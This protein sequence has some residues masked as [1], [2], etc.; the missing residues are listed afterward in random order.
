MVT[1]NFTAKSTTRFSR[2]YKSAPDSL[3][4]LMKVN[5]TRKVLVGSNCDTLVKVVGCHS[6]FT[7]DTD[8]PTDKHPVGDYL[9][10]FDNEHSAVY[11]IKSLVDSLYFPN[12]KIAELL[13]IE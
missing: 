6:I 13:R 2:K 1:K 7:R 12:R 4:K 11:V 5:D 10:E 9:Y 3:H 8:G